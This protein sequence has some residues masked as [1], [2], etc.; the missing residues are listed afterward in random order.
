VAGTGAGM[1]ATTTPLDGVAVGTGGGAGAEVEGRGVVVGP[2]PAAMQ[3]GG[4]GHTRDGRLER[5]GAF[6]AG[7]L[8]LSEAGSLRGVGYP[9]AS[10][11]QLDRLVSAAIVGDFLVLIAA[12]SVWCSPEVY[13]DFYPPGTP[14]GMTTATRGLDRTSSRSRKSVGKG[15]GGKASQRSQPERGGKEAVVI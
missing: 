11:P 6:A 14:Q 5:D 7:G 12:G 9:F 13:G 10:N 4:G 8:C 3:A 2:P 15:G 1:G